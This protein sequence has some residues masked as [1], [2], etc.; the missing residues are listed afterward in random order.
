MHFGQPAA[1]AGPGRGVSI[2]TV[3]FG[4]GRNRVGLRPPRRWSGQVVERENDLFDQLTR[5]YRA[6]AIS[7]RAG[8]SLVLVEFLWIFKIVIAAF[9]N[10]DNYTMNLFFTKMLDNF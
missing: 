9:S 5:W 3:R 4:D 6:V 8:N 10:S 2:I 1:A 7:G